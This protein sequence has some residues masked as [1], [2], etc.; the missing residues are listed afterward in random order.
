MLNSILTLIEKKPFTPGV[1]VWKTLIEQAAAGAR[2]DSSRWKLVQRAFR[3]WFS[4]DNR[5]CYPYHTFLRHGLDAC[6]A[7]LDSELAATLI[8]RHLQAST[9]S[10]RTYELHAQS[11]KEDP[12]PFQDIVKALQVCV[13]ANDMQSFQR[14][15]GDVRPLLLTV[16]KLQI[17]FLLNLKGFANRGDTASAQKILDEMK[18]H[19]IYLG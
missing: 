18:G 4:W 19:N 12:I 7:L 6:S 10:S 8:S 5:P 13:C 17:L 3:G 16:H 1:Q 15:M 2:E 11:E 9:P 14:I